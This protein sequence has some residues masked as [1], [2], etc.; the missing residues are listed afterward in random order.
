[1][2]LKPCLSA[3]FI[4]PPNAAEASF[5]RRH[6]PSNWRSRSRNEI[7]WFG[8]LFDA[9]LIDDRPNP[10]KL[11]FTS[12]VHIK[13]GGEAECCQGDHDATNFLINVALLPSI[14]IVH[15]AIGFRL[16]ATERLY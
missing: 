13:I 10:L 15:Q 11:L 9:D 4:A 2:F 7:A 16:T 6:E 8:L 12:L 1:M 14:D 5:I 3:F